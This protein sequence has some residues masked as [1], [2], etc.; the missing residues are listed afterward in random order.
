MYG[1]GKGE[2]TEKFKSYVE[3]RAYFLKNRQEIEQVKVLL[4]SAYTDWEHRNNIP[5]SDYKNN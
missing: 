4:R 2:W 5:V 3:N 1:K